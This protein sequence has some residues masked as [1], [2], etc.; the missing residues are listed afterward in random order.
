MWACRL[1]NDVVSC[2]D[3]KEAKQLSLFAPR[4]ACGLICGTES[5]LLCAHCMTCP[6]CRSSAQAFR[7]A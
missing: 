2:I 6:S 5:V 1:N 4:N 7:T 3:P